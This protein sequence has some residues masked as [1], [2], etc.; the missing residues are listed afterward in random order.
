MARKRGGGKFRR[1][2]RGN[3][4]ETQSLST[5]AASTGVKN[6]IDDTVASTTWC[7]SIDCVWSVT[8]M[9]VVVGSG[10]IVVGV[11]HG[12]YTL[13]EIEEWIEND[14]SWDVGDLVSQEVAKRKIRQ[15][16]VFDRRTAGA[17]IQTL[18]DGK[19]LKTKINW[20]LNDG[21]TLAFWYYNAGSAAFTSAPVVE[22]L[23]HANLWPRG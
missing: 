2:I 4:D 1:Y 12:D 3:I 23:G 13:A 8:E 10:P 22:T 16:G 17:T 20:Y 9:G 6:G 5:L 7:S 18:N 14:T 11:A 21:D 15:I 19:P